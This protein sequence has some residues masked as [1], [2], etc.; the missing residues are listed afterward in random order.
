MGSRLSDLLSICS[1]GFMASM[2]NISQLETIKITLEMS[3]AL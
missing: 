3:D 2:H 1:S